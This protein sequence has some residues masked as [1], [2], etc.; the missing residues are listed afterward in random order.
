MLRCFLHVLLQI[1]GFNFILIK[2]GKEKY[3][4]MS[5]KII[6]RLIN[7]APKASSWNSPQSAP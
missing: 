4:L 1:F 5:S 7:Q 3:V 2:K 6:F